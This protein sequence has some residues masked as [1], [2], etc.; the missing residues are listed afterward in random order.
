VITPNGNLS[1]VPKTKFLWAASLFILHEFHLEFSICMNRARAKF[2]NISH[3]FHART[4]HP[5]TCMRR[6]SSTPLS[7]APAARV[8]HAPRRPMEPD[9]SNLTGLK[10]QAALQCNKKSPIEI[11]SGNLLAKP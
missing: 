7:H 8:V 2:L 3:E 1:V 6:R 11:P 9:L 10:A 4:W 5:A